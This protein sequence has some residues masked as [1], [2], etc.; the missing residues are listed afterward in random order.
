[1]FVLLTS[2]LFVIRVRLS[3][4][5]QSSSITVILS[6][7]YFANVCVTWG[8]KMTDTTVSE[9]GDSMSYF[10]YV[11][12]ACS[13][14]LPTLT[15]ILFTPPIHQPPT[16]DFP[17]LS[18]KSIESFVDHVIKDETSNLETNVMFLSR[19]PSQRRANGIRFR[20]FSSG[21]WSRA[22]SRRIWTSS[23]IKIQWPTIGWAGGGRSPTVLRHKVLRITCRSS[24]SPSSS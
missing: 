1:M 13:E 15:L 9:I 20:L 17:F 11:S 10:P 2:Q 21:V 18:F 24:S 23:I 14:H 22:V 16:S 5:T 8:L 6:F 12:R 7:I 19:R 4:S 3:T